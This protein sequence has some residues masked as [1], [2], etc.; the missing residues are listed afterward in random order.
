MSAAFAAQRPTAVVMER[1]G[2]DVVDVN[3]RRVTAMNSLMQ[4]LG[5]SAE[6][7]QPDLE[8][9]T[10]DK[11]DMDLRQG[12]VRDALLSLCVENLATHDL[13]LFRCASKACSQMED[14]DSSSA[15]GR[16]LKEMKLKSLWDDGTTV[17]QAY[18][19]GTGRKME[20]EFESW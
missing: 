18:I 12:I 16:L 5:K 20:N 10:L 13:R 9:G 4:Q 17:E 8:F 3:A 7:D 15:A 19:A 2:N 1:S 11:E 14:F 6:P